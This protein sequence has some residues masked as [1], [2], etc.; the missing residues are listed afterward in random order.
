MTKSNAAGLFFGF[1]GCSFC[2]RSPHQ[3]GGI[4]VLREASFP[5]DSCF[6]C[7]LSMVDSRPTFGCATGA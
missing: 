3:G 2:G 4:A 5:L 6:F 7:L 1:R